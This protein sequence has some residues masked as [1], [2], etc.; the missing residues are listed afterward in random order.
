MAFRLKNGVFSVRCRRPGCPFNTRIEIET[1]LMGETQEDVAREAIK[2]AMDMA[3]TKHDAV[4]G[5]SHS[6]ENPA[7][8]KVAGGYEQF[9]PKS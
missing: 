8:H 6:L 3:K 2:I 9:G 5:T 1:I 4:Y 7:I